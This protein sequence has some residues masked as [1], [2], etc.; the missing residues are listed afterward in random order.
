M[1]HAALGR[2]VVVACCCADFFAG[3]AF[4]N[5]NAE[6]YGHDTRSA[7]KGSAV[8]A[9]DS[10][11]AA[12]F[13][14]PAAL[15]RLKGA[16]LHTG[17]QLSLPSTSIELAEAKAD[18]DPLVPANP[19]PVAGV[20]VGFGLPVNL[21]VD[22]V[23]FVGLTA[24][25][26]SAALVRARAYDPARPSWYIYDASTEHYEL[27]AG[28]GVRVT[29]W[30]HLGVGARLGAG[31]SG[32]TNLVLDPVRGR[33]TRQDIDTQQASIVSPIFG[34][35]VGPLGP[36]EVKGR[37]G[38]AVREKSSFDVSLPAS[39][40]ISG[41]DV[42]LL[43]DIATLTNFVPRTWTGGV[44]VDV[45]DGQAMGASVSVDVQFAQWTEA[46][47]PFL[48]V[49]NTISGEGLERLGLS[50]ALDAPSEGQQRVLSPG[51]VDTVNIR[52]GVEGHLFH[53]LLMLRAGY[54]YRPTPVP[55]QTSGTNIVDNTAH[56]VSAGV[57]VNVDLP[58]VAP[59]PFQ[60]NASYQAQLLTPRT[61]EKASGRDPVGNWTSSGVV[62][63]LGVDLRYFW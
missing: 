18:G 15:A 43:L 36:D 11:P 59:K 25:V 40:T 17:F 29:D 61:A 5:G 20:Q 48:K 27:F 49:K 10:G 2:V 28:L 41:V 3:A 38:F 9:D 54:G 47:A 8:V 33:F 7:G 51:F 14:N 42:G 26:P 35:L 13:V 24:Y 4:A 45:L 39:L 57:G 62:S 44:T 30:F 31:Q 53:D 12:A 50:G 6:T 60:V 52:A 34:L 21:I 32:T 1:K 16:A 19:P 37:L 23:L 46:P 56:I 63:N 55:D 58:L 22:D